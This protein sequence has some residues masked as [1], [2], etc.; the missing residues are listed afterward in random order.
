MPKSVAQVFKTAIDKK[1]FSAAQVVVG[2]GKKRLLAG[3]FGRL[4]Y[5]QRDPKCSEET[6]FDV[7]SLTKPV[8]TTTLSLMAVQ[9]NKI[10]LEQKVSQWLPDFVRKEDVRIRHLLSHQSGLPAYLP[11]YREV[12]GKDLSPEEIQKIYVSEITRVDSS[13]PLG[14]KRLYS[15][16]GFIL[17]GFLLEKVYGERLDDLFWEQLSKP[18]AMEHSTFLPLENSYGINQ[19]VISGISEVRQKP[20]RGEVHD[21]NAAALGGVAG[22]A[23]LFSTADDLEKFVH[24]VW[25]HADDPVWKKYIGGDVMPKLGWDTVSQPQS[26]A[27]SYFSDEAIGHLGFTGC[28]LWL[29]PKDQKYVIL[30]TNRTLG[31]VSEKHFK[32]Y[33]PK[34]HDLLIQETGLGKSK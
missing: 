26:Q 33:R 28:S 34:V 1:I 24:Y 9:K 6:L 7:A 11:L 32:T 4:G 8:V 20:L 14:K 18:L 31:H 30:L 27:G 13:A 5:R 2:Q 23:G 3:S 10:S 16:L 12:L 21:E 29:D 19:I 17:L 22:H 15:D 25:D